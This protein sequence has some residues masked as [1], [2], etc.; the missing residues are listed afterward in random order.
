M[1]RAYLLLLS[2]LELLL[3][4]LLWAEIVVGAPKLLVS[5]I[6]WLRAKWSEHLAKDG[7][8][9]EG[10]CIFDCLPVVAEALGTVAAALGT[11]VAVELGIVVSALVAEPGIA[12][13]VADT[14]AA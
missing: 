10:K 14:A 13:E 11:A 2:R 3:L 1:L 9:A 8:N 6:L 12:A 4:L 7:L 5:L